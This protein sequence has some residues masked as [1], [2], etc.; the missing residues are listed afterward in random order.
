MSIKKH[1]P[2]TKAMPDFA[3]LEEEILAFWRKGRIFEKSV[4]NRAG[5]P[6]FVF[7]D[8]PPFGNGLPH[9]GHVMQSYNKDAV[10]R[11]FTMRGRQVE[12]RWG[13][14]CHGLPPELKVEKD[15]G[16]S[17]KA[18]IKKYGAA[19]FVEKCR[20]DVMAYTNEW[21][22]IVERMGRWA[23]MEN[24]YKT[25]DSSYS[26][27]VMWAFKELY[28]KGL[29]YEDFRVQPYSWAAETVL[30]NF[31]VNQPGCYREKSDPA[32][33]VRFK[34]GNLN[35]LVWTTTPWTLP[36]NM[37]LAVGA[38][39][40]Y[41][42]LRLPSGEEVVL[43][44]SRVKA[45]EKELAGAV[46]VKEILG[47]ELV[48]KKYEPM[49]PYFAGAAPDAFQVL[50]ADFVGE[51]DGTGIVHIA[52]GFGED[53]FAACRAFRAD[54]PIVCPVD[55]A[56][57]FEP[58][59]LE[60][61]GVQVFE[62]NEPIIARLRAEGKLF[63]KEN[64]THQYPH[65]WRTDKP[66]IYKAV[67]SWFVKL[68]P[69]KEKLLDENQKINWVPEHVKDGRFGKW[70]EGARDWNISRSRFWGAPIPVWKSPSGKVRVVGSI[71][72]L[73]K[74]SGKKVKDL[75][76]PYIDEITF[77]LGGETYT[78]V[79]DVFDCWF[80][81]G[82][83]PFASCH[84]PFE[85]KEF[86][87]KNFPA[88]FI[89]EGVD[90][91]RGWFYTLS[92]LGVALFGKI[93]FKNCNVTGL[94]FDDKKQKLSKKLGNYSE[95]SEFFNKYGSDAFRWFM[96]SSPVVKGEAAYISKEGAEVAAAARRSTIPL[97]N[98]Y[99]F[100]TLYANADGVK[101]ILDLDTDELLDKYILS[102]ILELWE[103]ATAA[104]DKF[105][106]PLF[107]REME[108]FLDELSNWYIR[109]SRERFWGTSVSKESQQHAFNTL[110]VV[111]Y[112]LCKM[113]APLLPFTADYIY[114]ALMEPETGEYVYEPK[115]L[116]K[117]ESVHLD[118]WP[119]MGFCDRELV[120]DM[121]LVRDVCS[122]SKNL[123]ENAGIKNRQP[124]ALMTIASP[125]AE[126]LAKYEDL[127]KLESNVENVEF[128]SDVAKYAR[129]T[130][131]VFTPI[132]GKRLGGELAKAQGF[133]KNGD[134][135]AAKK[136]LLPE[137]YETRLETLSGI[138][139]MATSDNT[140]VVILNTEITPE[141]AAKGLFRD[142][143]RAVQEERKRL[144]LDVSDR[145]NLAYTGGLA[146]FEPEIAKVALA[147]KISV[148]S[149]SKDFS[150]V[151]GT[152]LKFKIEKA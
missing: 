78:R 144:G 31:E 83:M 66:L 109:L 108:A 70:L 135:A 62:A 23:D 138:S 124:L 12:R 50:A 33:T 41:S 61:A 128:A 51:E 58:S 21:K 6:P 120:A 97:W 49:F 149:A 52:P 13:W 98:A 123:R 25:M 5:A 9:Y 4:S 10:G 148:A 22:S 28:D 63:K 2:E 116:K 57:L 71:A 146:D 142:L 151:P 16:F 81:S 46:P 113:L 130:L 118:D 102:R 53:D 38:E 80:E 54:F 32:I 74:L 85:N 131:Y 43:A 8:G 87:E 56:G 79:E 150:E 132:A 65:C 112:N 94:V 20:A 27:S 69:L 82:A 40:L 45:Y 105:D 145:I 121:K 35:L 1:Y 125:K 48:G 100:F 129:E 111:L 7:Y 119:Y 59:V 42:V 117:K 29:I 64:I 55:Y 106:T 96:M 104:L 34:S 152:E 86:F 141:L 115:K 107:C 88:D 127:I 92:V 75:H 133:V 84:Y 30:S 93:P 136:M 36:S 39:I 15:L 11:Y 134:Y 47:R 99:H 91:T 73:D 77:D 122:A 137:E 18:A 72:E 68:A 139:G 26:E 19:K 143:V 126:R 110:Y 37:M 101:A 147:V 140:A 89:A 24:P 17:G 114:R 14:D 60:Y 90:Q 3:G 67:P 103:A 44:T 76:R 95:P